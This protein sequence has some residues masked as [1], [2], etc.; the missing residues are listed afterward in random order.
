MEI[1]ITAYKSQKYINE[2]LNSIPSNIS[3]IIGV[4]GCEE[5]LN[6]LLKIKDNFNNLKILWCPENRGTYIT[7]NTLLK[8]SNSNV[9]VFLDSDDIYTK[10][11]FEKI[12]QNIKE[13]DVIRWSYYLLNN[14]TY[15]T[16]PKN[17]HYYH[18]NGVFACKKE[19]FNKLGGYKDWRYA[20]DYDLQIRIN[21]MGFKTVKL[22]DNLMF[23]RQ[24]QDSLSSTVPIN[25]RVEKER[26][27]GGDWVNP[28]IHKNFSWV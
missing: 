10:E 8:Q 27:I 20:A 6:T 18:A 15:S 3:I 17:V 24:H 22:D 5:T 19:I 12:E 23:Y 11:L 7:R 1:L 9:I 4:D 13:N 16:P 2:T 21:E 26:Q 28:V 25:K 14:G